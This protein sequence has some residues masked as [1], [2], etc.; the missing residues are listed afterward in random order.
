M[1]GGGRELRDRSCGILHRKGSS[2]QLGSVTSRMTSFTAN[3]LVTG[4][5]AAKFLKSYRFGGARD[6]TQPTSKIAAANYRYAHRPCHLRFLERD[7]H[8][9]GGQVES[10]PAGLGVQ[11]DD[12]AIVVLEIGD[13]AALYNR[14][15]GCDC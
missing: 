14:R 13:R 9:V 11:L 2:N 4:R 5:M 12:D 3:A 7:V 10:Q 6:V 8:T 1:I 15:A